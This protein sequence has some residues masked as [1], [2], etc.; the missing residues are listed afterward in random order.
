[1][2]VVKKKLYIYIYYIIFISLV[3]LNSEMEL[4]ITSGAP[5]RIKEI[6]NT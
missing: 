4:V 5:S 1:M 2:E 3:R 6:L